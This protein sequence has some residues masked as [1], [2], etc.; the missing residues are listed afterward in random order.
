[1]EYHRKQ[2]WQNTATLALILLLTALAFPQDSPQSAVGATQS[3]PSAT[4]ETP[5]TSPPS[6][7]PDSKGTKEG[8]KRIFGILPA[9]N[10]SNQANPEPLTSNQKFMLFARSTYDPVTLIAPLLQV[11]ILQATESNSDLGTGFSAFAKRY[12]ILV[13]DG[14]SS[15]FFRQ[16]FFPTILN[17]DP[18]Y[19]RRGQGSSGSRLGYSVSRIFVTRTDSG[20]NRFNWSRLLGSTASAGL[21][22]TYYPESERGASTT[23]FSF[24]LSYASEAGSNVLKE[25]A[26]DIARKLRRN[27]DR[28]LPSAPE[29][30]QANSAI[31]K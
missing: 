30:V 21:S 28:D 1:V 20:D 14:T 11:P 8:S 6:T 10:V 25:F 17:E 31:H 4:A 27:K 22:N 2:M 26:P 3:A 12:G 29:P 18:R 16:F 24:G 9:F 15:R 7:A 5:Q 19:F 23:L 13:A